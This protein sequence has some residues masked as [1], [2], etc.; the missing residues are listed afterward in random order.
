MGK[1]A[2]SSW[3]SI[4]GIFDKLVVAQWEINLGK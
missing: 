4:E 1:R 3:V 2:Y